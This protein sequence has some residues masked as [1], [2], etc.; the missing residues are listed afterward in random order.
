ML[1]LFTIDCNGIFSMAIKYQRLYS[2]QT[3]HYFNGRLGLMKRENFGNGLDIN[4]GFTLRVVY[5][6]CKN[7][8][9]HCLAIF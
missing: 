6:F 9:L 7:T 8:Y 1:L 2:V 5:I 3:S 4:V